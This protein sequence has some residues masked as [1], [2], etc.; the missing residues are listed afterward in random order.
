[1][2]YQPANSYQLLVIKFLGIHILI[3]QPKPY[4]LRV[5][6]HISRLK[7]ECTTQEKSY[8]SCLKNSDNYVDRLRH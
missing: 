5:F 2:K 8:K 7:N 4:Q 6:S 1:M 3:N